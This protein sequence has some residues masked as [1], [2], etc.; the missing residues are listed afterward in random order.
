MEIERTF[1]PVGQGA[2]YSEKHSNEFN[3]VYDCGVLNKV[4]GYHDNIIK[5]SFSTGDVIDILFVSHL[6]TDHISLI[7]TL[8]LHVKN[9]RYI[10]LPLL[11][12]N[13]VIYGVLKKNLLDLR[14]MCNTGKPYDVNLLKEAIGY[15][16]KI[17]YVGSDVYTEEYDNFNLDSESDN[18]FTNNEYISSG[19][20]MFSKNNADWVYIAHNHDYNT[21]R[22]K[23][24][25]ELKKEKFNEDK[26][27]ND[28]NYIINVFKTDKKRLKSCYDKVMKSGSGSAVNENSMLVY[29]GPSNKNSNQT[30]LRMFSYRCS[31]LF[32]YEYYGFGLFH[33]CS[34]EKIKNRV[35]CI[36]TGDSDLNVIDLKVAFNR[37]W[38]AVGTIQIPHHG[39]IHS[40]KSGSFKD[41][42]CPISVG[43][44]NTFGHP[45]LFV[46]FNLLKE[47]CWPII[48]TDQINTEYKQIIHY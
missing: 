38:D 34:W 1:H 18:K 45:S 19:N 10:V 35:A 42:I 20:I 46:I 44:K 16:T 7:Q 5:R 8:R 48:V 12:S 27:I 29:S 23:L 28:P 31:D 3:V 40:Y 17:I 36:Y 11:Y 6:D 14:Y 25:L 33:N 15:D 32:M 26:L 37:F 2:F 13:P 24:L 22:N 21:R 4:T 47:N 43:L 9:I 41:M 39:S 30:L